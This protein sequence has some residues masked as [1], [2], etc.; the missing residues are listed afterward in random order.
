MGIH[1]PPMSDTAS[2]RSFLELLYKALKKS[3]RCSLHISLQLPAGLSLSGSGD[4][5]FCA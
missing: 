2:T 4:A 3:S 5:L 1:L